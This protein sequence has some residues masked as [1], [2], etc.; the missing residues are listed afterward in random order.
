[1]AYE[2]AE[3]GKMGWGEQTTASWT[4]GWA[5]GMIEEQRQVREGEEWWQQVQEGEASSWEV[6]RISE[7]KE[8]KLMLAL[9]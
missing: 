3:E 1:M 2:E 6:P 8:V 7:A 5:R 4:R 9:G